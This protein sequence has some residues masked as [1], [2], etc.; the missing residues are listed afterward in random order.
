[1]AWLEAWTTILFL[2]TTSQREGWAVEVLN[3]M[4]VG[5]R[6]DLISKTY[7]MLVYVVHFFAMLAIQIAST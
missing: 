4:E 5:E 1:M 6:K 2:R 7:H 3:A